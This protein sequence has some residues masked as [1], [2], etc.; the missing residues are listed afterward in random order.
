MLRKCRL[1][2]KLIWRR[3]FTRNVVQLIK[4]QSL[5]P[6]LNKQMRLEMEEDRNIKKCV[7]IRQKIGDSM[8]WNEVRVTLIKY[9]NSEGKGER[10]KRRRGVSPTLPSVEKKQKKH[11][12]SADK[13]WDR[14]DCLLLKVNTNNLHRD[15]NLLLEESFFNKIVY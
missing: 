2:M 4:K 7:Q 8:M 12:A 10:S 6:I 11:S 3:A 9:R 13:Y 15:F 1:F 14:S 5:Y